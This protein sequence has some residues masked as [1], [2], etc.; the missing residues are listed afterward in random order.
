MSD[1]RKAEEAAA[2]IYFRKYE[3]EIRLAEKWLLLTAADEYTPLTAK[4]ARLLAKAI[5]RY[6][7]FI[8]L[9]L[10]FEKLFFNEEGHL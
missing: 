3:P 1:T 2:M 4:E 6:N 10:P 7:H 5:V 8:S 9:T